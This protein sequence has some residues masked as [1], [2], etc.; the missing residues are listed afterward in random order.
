MSTITFMVGRLLRE[1]LCFYCNTFLF[2][3][4]KKSFN[5]IDLTSNEVIVVGSLSTI[6]KRQVEVLQ[7]GLLKFHYLLPG[8]VLY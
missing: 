1:R 8:Q 4:Q 7:L 5:F 3:Y 6:L 2:S